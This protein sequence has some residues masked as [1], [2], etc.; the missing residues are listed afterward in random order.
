MEVEINFWG[1]VLAA[2][3]G[4][5]VGSAWYS[6]A[7]FGKMWSDLV[8]L[9]QKEMKQ[10]ATK[11][12][13]TAAALSLL[14][15]YVVAHVTYLSQQFYGVSFQQAGITTGFWL[16]LGIAMT[17]AVTGGVF[18][19]RP[20]RLT[21]LNVGNQLVTLLAMGLVVGLVGV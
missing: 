3:A 20:A 18:E 14:T 16:W 8:K 6:K 2:V 1:V 10:G 17:Q 11:A 4:M 5:V 7:L 13:F 9:D 12:M 19:Q 15:A 21:A